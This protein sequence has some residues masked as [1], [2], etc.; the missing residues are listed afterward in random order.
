[1]T[2]RIALALLALALGWLVLVRG[3]ADYLARIEPER[4]LAWV[5]GQS[6]ALVREA[7]GALRGAQMERAADLA[8]RALLGHPLEGRALR[9]LGAVA[10]RSGDRARARALMQAAATLTPRDSATQF[11][12]AINAL[13]DRDLDTAL[14]KLDR[15]VRFEPE[16]QRDVFPILATVASNP[17]GARAIAPYL[18]RG[19]PWR[20]EFLQGLMGQASSLDDLLRLLRAVE[21]AGGRIEPEEHE[22]LSDRLWAMREWARLSTWLRRADPQ[23]AP[24]LVHDPGFAGTGR[25]PWAG[26]SVGRVAG[27]DAILGAEV[28]GRVAL[29]LV[30]HDRRIPFRHVGQNLLL[31][32]GRYVLRAHARL[33][34]LETA[35]GLRWVVSC[36]ESNAEIGA[37]ERLR[38]DSGWRE[39]EVGFEVPASGCGGQ[40]LQLVLD[41]RIAAEQQVSGE[42][43]FDRLEIESAAGS[44]ASVGGRASGT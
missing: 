32:P 25:G 10:E 12:L 17:V 1:M 41:A 3:Y 6:E 37:T 43:W 33:R 2:R 16:L 18:A 14:R 35:L 13:A 24:V 20:R 9:I 30:F 27:V 38:G 11:W 5:P 29:R 23:Q 22:R 28:D 34:R 39:L 8:Q 7:E 42:A 26:W 21:A 15:L 4:S 40:R 19:V 31:A 44:R 36:A